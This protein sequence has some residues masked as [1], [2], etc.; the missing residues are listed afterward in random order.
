MRRC[1]ARS[2]QNCQQMALS[3][4]YCKCNAHAAGGAYVHLSAVQRMM[5]CMIECEQSV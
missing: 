4:P 5:R 1:S 3:L 2:R